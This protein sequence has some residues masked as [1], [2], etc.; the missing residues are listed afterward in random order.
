MFDSIGVYFMFIFI[1]LCGE[2]AIIPTLRRPTMRTISEL[3][4]WN[5]KITNPEIAKLL[6]ASEK[7]V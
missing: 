1:V 6:L 3:R 2:F 7:D 4:M 5:R